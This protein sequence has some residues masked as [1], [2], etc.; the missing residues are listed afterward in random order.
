[1]T[2]GLV[3]P[4]SPP[5]RTERDIEREPSK[6]SPAEDEA[7]SSA[8]D[9]AWACFFAGRLDDAERAF[10]NL[11]ERPAACAL[12][13]VLAWAAKP[14]AREIIDL[15]LEANTD[16]DSTA[17]ARCEMAAALYE[18]VFGSDDEAD[19]RLGRAA[20]L[21]TSGHDANE[22]WML[23]LTSLGMA[24]ARGEWGNASASSDRLVGELERLSY[25]PHL[26]RIGRST[27]WE[28]VTGPVEYLV[29][30]QPDTAA[31]WLRVLKNL[32]TARRQRGQ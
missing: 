21:L 29:S 5:A 24:A 30:G 25:H 4:P 19:V 18:T 8:K 28:R 6:A 10:R 17:L 22:Y 32:Y 26:V 16:L 31:N 27:K 9:H 7:A 15:A 14:E 20:D 11:V 23:H 12:G 13:L 1:M 2:Y 3:H